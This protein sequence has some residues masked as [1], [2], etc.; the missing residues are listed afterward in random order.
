MNNLWINFRCAGWGVVACTNIG[1]AS[2]IF[3]SPNIAFPG[4]GNPLRQRFAQKLPT[5]TT[6]QIFNFIN[7]YDWL[8]RCKYL[9]QP[10]KFSRL[11]DKS[12]SQQTTYIHTGTQPN[13]TWIN[14]NDWAQIIDQLNW[15]LTDTIGTTLLK[16][17][18]QNHER[19]ILILTTNQQL[20]PWS[21]QE[22]TLDLSPRIHPLKVNVY[23]CDKYSSKQEN[24]FN[25]EYIL[26]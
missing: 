12:M 20:K 4:Q 3:L 2:E 17:D 13:A 1:K 6:I 9:Y 10:K 14:Q 25:Q 19:R 7:R 16:R 18:F 15:A 8:L 22:P 24:P 11:M 21:N 5:R 23:W 26:F